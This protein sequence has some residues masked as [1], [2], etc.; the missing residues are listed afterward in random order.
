MF[1]IWL[2]SVAHLLYITL[3]VKVGSVGRRV[4][5]VSLSVSCSYSMTTSRARTAES[6]FFVVL[7]S[8]GCSQI[9]FCLSRTHKITCI[10]TLRSSHFL[11]HSPPFLTITAHIQQTDLGGDKN[12]ATL[13][14]AAHLFTLSFSLPILGFIKTVRTFDTKQLRHRKAIQSEA[15]ICRIV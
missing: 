8:W 2:Q 9:P 7:Y 4:Q 11:S 6:L 12:T 1:L 10:N 13:L 15:D 5:D 3:V 14:L